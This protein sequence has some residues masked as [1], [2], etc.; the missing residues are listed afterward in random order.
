MLMIYSSLV[1]REP[2]FLGISKHLEPIKLILIPIIWLTFTDVCRCSHTHT[3]DDL[4]IF[5][6]LFIRWYFWIFTHLNGHTDTHTSQKPL[7][8]VMSVH[9]ADLWVHT[10]RQSD[11]ATTW[12][13]TWTTRSV[14]FPPLHTMSA[15]CVTM[16]GP[17]CICESGVWTTRR[18]ERRGVVLCGS[19]WISAHVGAGSVLFASVLLLQRRWN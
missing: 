18:D 2:H 8:I 7:L 19:D 5:N 16:C 11:T 13:L 17:V 4:W 6:S 10:W 1:H 12:W 14:L 9:E 3:Q 15:V